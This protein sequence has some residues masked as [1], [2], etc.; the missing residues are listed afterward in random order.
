MYSVHLIQRY[1]ECCRIYLTDGSVTWP[2]ANAQAT[3]LARPWSGSDRLRWS[4]SIQKFQAICHRVWS[5]TCFVICFHPR[6]NAIVRDV[7]KYIDIPNRL[8]Y[9]VT[10]LK[11]K[12]CALCDIKSRCWYLATRVACEICPT[13]NARTT[14]IWSAAEGRVTSSQ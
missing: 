12:P 2:W 6:E 14:H 1:W 4:D 13:T 10:P 11:P 3:V 5:R 7:W 9:A 8:P